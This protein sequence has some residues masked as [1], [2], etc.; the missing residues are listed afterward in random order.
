MTAAEQMNFF[1]AI[2]LVAVSRGFLIRSLRKSD[3]EAWLELGS[4]P[5]ISVRSFEQQRRTFR[6]TWGGGLL[7]RDSRRT[8]LH[9]VGLMICDALVYSIAPA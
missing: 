6:G 8:R 4:P 5:F 3:P 7:R 1:L 2:V 9:A